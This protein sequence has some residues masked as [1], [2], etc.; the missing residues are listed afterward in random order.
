MFR[1]W[2]S[3]ET[4]FDRSCADIRGFLTPRTRAQATLTLDQ[5]A[6]NGIVSF[7]RGMADDVLRDVFVRGKYRYVI[8]PVCVLRGAWGSMG[9]AEHGPT[10]H[11]HFLF[12]TMQ[13]ASPQQVPP[14]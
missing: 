10:N 4:P 7:I 14:P 5:G 12:T 9:R 3:G 1:S 8:L 13:P 6:H 2:P 11:H